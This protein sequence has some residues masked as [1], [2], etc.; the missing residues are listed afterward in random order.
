ML[1]GQVIERV[2][3]DN[4][5]VLHFF[6]GSNLHFVVTMCLLPSAYRPF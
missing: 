5:V 3:Y 6:G 1:S 2:G 4:C